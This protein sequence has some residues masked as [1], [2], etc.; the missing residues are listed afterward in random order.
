MVSTFVTQLFLDPSVTKVQTDPLPAN[1]RAIRC[2]L[3]A[4]FSVV[5]EITTPDGPALL[6]VRSRGDNAAAMPD[7]FA[8]PVSCAA[9]DSGMLLE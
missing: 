2:Y 7:D 9:A 3:R 8:Q 6:M 5:G 1:E 4:G